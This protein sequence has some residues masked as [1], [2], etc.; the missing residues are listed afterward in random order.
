M[1]FRQFVK[2][3]TL[4]LYYKFQQRKFIRRLPEKYHSGIPVNFVMKDRQAGF[5]SLFFQVLGAADFCRKQG[6]NLIL[7][8]CDGP[9]LDKDKGDNWWAYYFE[10]DRFLF[11]Q[12]C[13]DSLEIILKINSLL[14]VTVAICHSRLAINLFLT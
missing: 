7:D 9:Y 5:F 13:S 3:Y 2:F 11:A 14:Q 8:F 1:Q 4:S 6:H 12:Y 10:S